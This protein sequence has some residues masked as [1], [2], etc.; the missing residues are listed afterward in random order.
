MVPARAVIVGAWDVADAASA[1]LPADDAEIASIDAATTDAA[2]AT[3]AKLRLIFMS[4]TNERW[5]LRTW[6]DS[7]SRT[8]R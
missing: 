5:I 1:V 2:V 3:S 6:M 8:L 4:V 7:L